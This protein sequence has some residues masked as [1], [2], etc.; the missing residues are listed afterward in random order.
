MLVEEDSCHVYDPDNKEKESM[1]V[2]DTDIEDVV[3]IEESCGR[4]FKDD[5]LLDAP[6][7]A[8]DIYLGNSDSII[9]QKKF[10]GRGRVPRVAKNEMSMDSNFVNEGRSLSCGLSNSRSKSDGQRDSSQMLVMSDYSTSSL[11]GESLPLL[12][13]GSQDSA[14]N[15]FAWVHNYSGKLDANTHDFIVKFQDGYDTNVGKFK[16][17]LSG[18]QKHRVAITHALIRDRKILLLDEAT[19]VLDSESERVMQKPIDHVFAGRA[20]IIISHHLSTIRRSD[21]IYLLQSGKWEKGELVS[22]FSV[23]STIKKELD[24]N[25]HALATTLEDG[26]SY[27]GKDTTRELKAVQMVVLECT[28]TTRVEAI[29]DKKNQDNEAKDKKKG[30]GNNSKGEDDTGTLD[31]NVNLVKY[32]EL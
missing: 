7:L 10:K 26:K 16:V 32:H 20:N 23:E 15:Q 25:I 2:Y 13:D 17:Q 30:K 29:G 3:G 24:Q 27:A 4:S 28:T 14:K 18:G 12:M 6:N 31:R 21:L 8:H 19:S 9:K 1:P 5:L 11:N 22:L